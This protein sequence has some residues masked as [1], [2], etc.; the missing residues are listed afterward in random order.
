MV[1]SGLLQKVQISLELYRHYKY[2]I[3]VALKNIESSWPPGELNTIFGMIPFMGSFETSIVD[4]DLLRLLLV[5]VGCW[6]EDVLLKD[7]ES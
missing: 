3:Y 6:L 1:L 5:E 4:E 2:T 7:N